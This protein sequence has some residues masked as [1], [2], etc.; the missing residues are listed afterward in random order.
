[1]PIR[2]A[3]EKDIPAMREVFDYGREVQLKTDN[4][5]QWEEGYPRETLMVEDIEK[6]AAYVC[7]NDDDEMLAVFS[8]FTEPDPTYYDIDGEWLNDDPYVTIHRIA[9]SGQVKGIGQY[10]IQWVQGKYD[11]VR[12]DT[13]D[14]NEPMKHVLKKLGFKYCGII[15]LA[16]GN[17]RNAYQYTRTKLI[18]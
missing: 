4:P 15:Y 8:V 3:T 12:I 11:N 1:M 13:H 17:P 7:L 10:C 18:G 6:E 16:N 5:R 9:T 2:L 14:D